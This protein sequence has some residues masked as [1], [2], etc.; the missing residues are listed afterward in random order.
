MLLCT[1]IICLVVVSQPVKR[2]GLSFL[3]RYTLKARQFLMIPGVRDM[4]GGHHQ[5]GVEFESGA[6]FW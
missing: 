3:I 2:K 5:G 6:I 1:A 4:P